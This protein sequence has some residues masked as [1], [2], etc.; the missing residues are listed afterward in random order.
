MV[1]ALVCCE[2]DPRKEAPKEDKNYGKCVYV[3]GKTLSI[4]MNTK[5]IL[6]NLLWEFYDDFLYSFFESKSR[7]R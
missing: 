3:C 5:L 1:M 7:H 4:I 2:R 6:Y